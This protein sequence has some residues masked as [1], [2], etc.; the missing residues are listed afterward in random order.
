MVTRALL[1]LMCSDRQSHLWLPQPG[2]EPGPLA[3]EASTIPLCQPDPTK[4][5]NA[6]SGY[7]KAVLSLLFK[8]TN[9]YP[10]IGAGDS[11]N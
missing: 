10:V 1:S 6:L 7:L 2:I 3:P 4:T 11:Q 8:S 9:K 5:A